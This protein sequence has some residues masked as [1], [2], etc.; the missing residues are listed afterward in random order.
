MVKATKNNGLAFVEF[1]FSAFKM[2][3]KNFYM[4]EWNNV[5]L[6]LIWERLKHVHLGCYCCCYLDALLCEYFRVRKSHITRTLK[7]LRKSRISQ[8]NYFRLFCFS[9]FLG[10][11][12][13]SKDNYSNNLMI[14]YVN[15]DSKWKVDP[16]WSECKS[17]NHP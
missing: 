16:C 1:G 17:L 11:W 8:Y 10:E 9:L 15:V 2:I 4:K 3:S 6:V 7:Y 5:I 14:I 12:F 13:V